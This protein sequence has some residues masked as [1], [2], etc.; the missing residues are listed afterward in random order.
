VEN[1][2]VVQSPNDSIPAYGT[3]HDTLSKLK[4]WPNHKFCLQ[5]QPDE[6]GNYQRWYV[7]DQATQNLY[8]WEIS[9]S[10]PWPAI[11]QTFIIPRADYRALPAN[12][13]TTYPAP[14]NPPLNTTDYEITATQE[15][16]IGEPK[17]DSLY[18]SVQVTREK[19]ST[20][21]TAYAVDLDTNT[22]QATQTQ[23]VAAGTQASGVAA[24][25]TYSN[26]AVQNSL[27]SVKTTQKAAGLAGKSVNGVSTRILYYRD[28]YTWPRV[29]NYI[30]IQAIQS[31]PRN[32]YSPISSFSWSPVWLADAF[33]GPCDYTLVERWTLAKPVFGGDPNWNTGTVWAASTAYAVDA[34]VTRVVGDSPTYYRCITAH[35]SGGSFNASYWTQVSPLIPQETPMLKTEIV[36]NGANLR[37]S[38]PACLHERYN[39]WDTQFSQTY[40]AT[41]PT[42]W[43]ATVLSRVT[44]VPDQGGYLTRMFYVKSPST[45]GNP[46]DI[47]LSLTAEAATG[48]T[49]SGVVAAT[50]PT[51]TMYLSIATDPNFGGGFLGTY[52]SLA[53]GSHTQSLVANAPPTS[54]TTAVTG[55]TRGVTYYA[56]LVCVPTN[57]AL[58]SVTSNLCIAFTD[59]Q[60]E[61]LVSTTGG[62]NLVSGAPVSSASTANAV[63]VGGQSTL[64]LRLTNIGLESLSGFS[65]TKTSGVAEDAAMFTVQQFPASIAP[66]N[67]AEW[68][69]YFKP[70]SPGYKSATITITSNASTTYDLNVAG[71]GVA[72]D[73]QVE[74]PE[75]TILV[76]GANTINFGTVTTGTADKTFWIRNV[77]ND[78]VPLRDLAVS[79]SGTNASDYTPSALSVTEL[80]SGTYTMFTV[81]FD[82]V[83]EETASSTRTAT[84]SI[85]STDTDENPFTVNLTGVSQNPTAPGAV[86]LT[87][88][89][90]ANGTVYGI[91]HQADGQAIL[92]GVFTQIGATARNRIARV[93]ASTG[94]V[95]A[96]FNPNADAAVNCALVQ[97]DGKI[98][99]GGG[100]A[101]IVATAR[102]YI[103]RLN[104]DGTID[105]GF[106]PDADGAVRCMALQADGSIIVGGDFANIGG[107]A[108]AWLARIDSSGVLDASFTSEI[109]TVTS[110]GQVYGVTL[111][112]DGRV[113]VVGNWSDTGNT[114]TTTTTTS[115]TVPPTTAPPTTVPPTTVPPT[116]A[117]PTT[118][119]PTTAPPT[120]A[121]PTTAPPTTAPP[122]T[123]PP[124]TAP[125][126]TAPPT[127]APP[128]TAPPTTAPPTTAPPTTAPPTT[129]PP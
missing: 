74:Q 119:P 125:P 65:T 31:D 54:T 30:N 124:T 116:T 2:N 50:V 39:L 114:T 48:F 89:G 18:V 55:A 13:S 19:V 43:P 3:P 44:V 42:R 58:P 57:P 93:D 62:D 10:G 95:D 83:S 102:N 11:N 64:D 28:N 122:T 35:T 33:D 66:S 121:P 97:P 8:N 32:I 41:N 6:K 7:A 128:T 46:T 63:S 123:A 109:D 75:N 105:A 15:Q 120:T 88:D 103:A 20:I 26:V 69:I 107:G 113:A 36:F 99:V 79:V 76:N 67:S 27:W 81:T 91:A 70:T 72:A 29:L 94:A 21:N 101:N 115:T 45:A 49:L 78:S 84:L 82:P 73:I 118:A 60:P 112:E 4:S 92:V 40:P 56:K 87:W 90:N 14:P 68:S 111:L 16:R 110:P 96:T 126:T 25:G 61:L 127:T 86:D 52:S 38:I 108:K 5:T 9:D 106:D 85:A 34:Y 47:S 129:P 71:T 100:F 80:D 24:D 22:V 98:V 104:S 51:G 117:P 59:P 37:I 23:K 12:P 77:G 1:F 53:I 17:L